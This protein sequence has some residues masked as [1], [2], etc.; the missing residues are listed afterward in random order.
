MAMANPTDKAA[1]NTIKSSVSMFLFKSLF[2]TSIDLE[3]LSRLCTELGQ[4]KLFMPAVPKVIP[5]IRSRKA[6]VV[7]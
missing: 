2:D 3:R 4:L 5:K 1:I 6:M 7:V